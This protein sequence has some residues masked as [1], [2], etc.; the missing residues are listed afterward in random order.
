MFDRSSES[1]TALPRRPGCASPFRGVTR[2][3]RPAQLAEKIG[4][5]HR[6]LAPAA[7]RDLPLIAGSFDLSRLREGLYLHCT[8]IEHLRDLHT[9][10]ATLECGIKV[11]LKLEGTARV[12]FG[13]TPIP[14]DA[15]QG[16]AARPCGAVVA[17]HRTEDFERRACAGMRERMVVITLAPAWLE[18]SGLDDWRRRRHLEPLAWQPS[19]RAVAIAEQLLRPEAQ[20]GQGLSLFQESRVLELV[21]EALGRTA[22]RDTAPAAGLRPAEFKRVARLQAGLENGRFDHA[23][24][25]DIARELGCNPTTLQQQFRSAFGRTI[26]DY[27]RECRLQRAAEMLARHDI[28]VA[29]AAEVAGYS[30]QANFATAFRRHFGVPPKQFRARL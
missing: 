6:L 20:A 2:T 10:F 14:L 30:S 16:R 21:G 5:G 11:M 26:S 7:D 15:C 18:A 23:T 24:I 28:S 25:S 13:G 19:P 29:Q 4:D 12:C 9:R 1:R 17:L 3:I 27:R 8:D 22:G